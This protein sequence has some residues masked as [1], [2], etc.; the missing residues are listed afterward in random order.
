MLQNHA[1]KVLEYRD[2]RLVQGLQDHLTEIFLKLC[3]QKGFLYQSM[4]ALIFHHEATL[5]Q[6]SAHLTDLVLAQED[7]FHQGVVLIGVF[8]DYLSKEV[9]GGTLIDSIL[10]LFGYG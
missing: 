1:Y 5:Y 4:V 2:S 3:C 7:F 8:G 6:G 10:E 9:S